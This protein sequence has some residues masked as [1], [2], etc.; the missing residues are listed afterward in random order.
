MLKEQYLN[1]DPPPGDALEASKADMTQSFRSGNSTGIAESIKKHLESELNSLGPVFQKGAFSNEAIELDS[2]D[3]KA[4]SVPVVFLCDLVD[5]VLQNIQGS[6]SY[7]E[8][9]YRIILG[10]MEI[11][12]PYTKKRFNI[13]IGDMP[14]VLSDFATWYRR[15]VVA[16]CLQ[17]LPFNEFMKSIIKNLVI[18]SFLNRCN[19]EMNNVIGNSR[20]EIGYAQLAVAGVGRKGKDPLSDIDGNRIDTEMFRGTIYGPNLF[21]DP[22]NKK[23]SKMYNYLFYYATNQSSNSFLGDPMTDVKKGVHHLTL[24]KDRGLVKKIDFQIVQNEKLKMYL[25]F[26]R[27]SPLAQLRLPFDASVSIIGNNYFLPGSYVYINPSIAGLGDPRNPAS[28]A[29]RIGLGG[30]YI[31]VG[32]RHTLELDSGKYETALETMHIAWPQNCTKAASVKVTHD[33]AAYERG[34]A[35]LD[36]TARSSDGEMLPDDQTSRAIVDRALE[37]R[38]KELQRDAATPDDVR[39][40]ITPWGVPYPVTRDASIPDE[41]LGVAPG[42]QTSFDS[43]EDWQERGVSQDHMSTSFEIEGNDGPVDN[44]WYVPN[45]PP[46]PAIPR[47]YRAR[48]ESYSDMPPKIPHSAN[49]VIAEQVITFL[50]ATRPRPGASVLPYDLDNLLLLNGVRL[51]SK[52]AIV[53]SSSDVVTIGVFTMEEVT[54]RDVNMAMHDNWAGDEREARTY[55]TKRVYTF[56]CYKNEVWGWF[57]YYDTSG[58]GR[59][60]SFSQSYEP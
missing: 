21:V 1:Q 38:Q 37:Q 13:N 59:A 12:D 16:Q 45:L 20:F 60:T 55:D 50:E 41:L 15:H 56:Y 4:R 47:R 28:H 46:P 44:S 22:K 11:T 6:Y 36:S 39:W 49:R 43:F 35:R 54:T 27:S 3:G 58:G 10:P 42:E 32:V 29:N 19:V 7:K 9:N 8:H 52:S 53:S 24:G 26:S 25:M 57:I 23:P 17:T 5:S 31:V 40:V 51:E 14:I 33:L 34:E 2:T 18:D 30:Y 48:A